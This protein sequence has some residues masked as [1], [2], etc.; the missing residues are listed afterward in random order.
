[1]DTG[2]DPRSALWEQQL[3]RATIAVFSETHTEHTYTRC[4][5][6]VALSDVK[7]G[8]TQSNQ[9]TLKYELERHGRAAGVITVVLYR[10]AFVQVAFFSPCVTD[11]RR[12]N[13]PPDAQPAMRHTPRVGE[14]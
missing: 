6:D 14:V 7:C 12:A 1:M 9:S 4:G 10:Y 11:E 13:A 5:Q 8:G 3:Y 2:R